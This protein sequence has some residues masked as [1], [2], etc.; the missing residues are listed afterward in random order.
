MAWETRDRGGRYYTR[1]IRVGDRVVREYIGGGLRG[2]AAALQDARKRA[3]RMSERE[4]WRA[5][6]Q[7]IES[8]DSLVEALFHSV[9]A[10]TRATLMLEGYHRHNR[11]EWRRKRGREPE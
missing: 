5:E 10:L 7:N 9:E 6:C 2:Q 3:Q 4:A 8:T 11:G 1:S